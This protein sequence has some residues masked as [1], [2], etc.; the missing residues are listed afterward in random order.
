MV[1]K[2]VAYKLIKVSVKMHLIHLHGLELCRLAV[3]IYKHAENSKSQ[4]GGQHLARKI[5]RR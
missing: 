5:S 4:K 3:Q 1:K 2:N